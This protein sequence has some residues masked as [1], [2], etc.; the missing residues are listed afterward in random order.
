MYLI[1]ASSL[2]FWKI[3][4][5]DDKQSTQQR[6]AYRRGTCNSFNDNDHLLQTR[7]C[8]FHTE[9][10]NAGAG[11]AAPSAHCRL[12]TGRGSSTAPAGAAGGLRWSSS[13]RGDLWATVTEQQCNRCWFMLESSFHQKQPSTHQWIPLFFLFFFYHNSAGSLAQP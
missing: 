13:C 5:V 4:Q 9:D 11:P 7:L 2:L 1:A 12:G 3:P 10:P 6:K 8:I